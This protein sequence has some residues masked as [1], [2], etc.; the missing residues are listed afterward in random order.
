[1]M[2]GAKGDAMKH[3]LQEAHCIQSFRSCFR[4]GCLEMDI[5]VNPLGYFVTL[6]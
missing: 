2:D 6:R 5:L 4:E 1:M 3:A